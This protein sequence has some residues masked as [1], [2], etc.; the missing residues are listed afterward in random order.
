MPVSTKNPFPGMNPYL[1]GHWPDVHTRLIGYIA[2]VLNL[3]LPA[4]LNARA[5]EALTITDTERVTGDQ[6]YRADIRV[7]EETVRQKEG[8]TAGSGAE[9]K[10]AE[11]DTATMVATEPLIVRVPAVKPRWVEIR[12]AGSGRLITVIEVLSPSNKISDGAGNYVNKVQ[13]YL[14]ANVNVVEIDLLRGGGEVVSVPQSSL[15]PGHRTPYRICVAQAQHLEQR[16]VYPCPLEKPLP[17]IRIPLRP[18]DEPV[19][20]ALQPLIDRVY[21]NGRHR[22]DDF[23]F[24]PPGPSL[25]DEDKA[26][27]HKRLEETGLV[28]AA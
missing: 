1:E 3:K 14:A 27:V 9:T 8:W 17:V 20:L 28:Q 24:R 26:W 4:N 13:R 25:D 19:L 2:D 18:D 10:P 6:A 12:E 23:S 5:E 11:E 7:R 21:E 16:E 22:Q 15:D